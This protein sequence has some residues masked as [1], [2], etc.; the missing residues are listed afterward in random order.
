MYFKYQHF[1]HC[2]KICQPR[3]V[4]WTFCSD[5][6]FADHN[7]YDRIYGLYWGW[8]NGDRFSI[9]LRKL[10]QPHG[11]WP[12]PVQLHA[13]THKHTDGLTGR[14]LCS[15][16][17]PFHSTHS[18]LVR[19]SAQRFLKAGT[20]DNQSRR[21]RSCDII[22]VSHDPQHFSRRSLVSQFSSK[23]DL[24]NH[25][26]IAYWNY[27]GCH[28]NYG[29]IGHSIRKCWGLQEP[30]ANFRGVAVWGRGLWQELLRGRESI[31]QGSLQSGQLLKMQQHH[32]SLT[33]PTTL[34]PP[35]H[36]SL[37][38]FGSLSIFSPSS[39]CSSWFFAPQPSVLFKQHVLLHI[40]FCSPLSSLS[41]CLLR[42]FFY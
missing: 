27:V 33:Q 16:P 15:S 36:H 34:S 11:Q 13:H 20:L 2:I 14:G 39:P 19:H 5:Y 6:I 1:R 8:W 18:V 22:G 25:L 23:H 9:C 26:R 42:I 38:P 41:L 31:R 32:Y 30:S 12:C 29:I 35:L 21:S 28:E 4:V 24:S 37:F 17:F 3:K 7:P 10:Y 40:P